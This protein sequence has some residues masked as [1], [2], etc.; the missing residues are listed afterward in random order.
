MK[1]KDCKYRIEFLRADGGK[2]YSACDVGTPWVRSVKE[3][4]EACTY[5]RRKKFALKK[6]EG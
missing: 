4:D 2:A 1:C 3:N 5:G 6:G